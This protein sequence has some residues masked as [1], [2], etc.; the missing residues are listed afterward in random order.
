MIDAGQTGRCRVAILSDT[1]GV[2]DHRVSEIVAQCDIA[3]HGGDI[4]GLAVLAGLAPLSGR[5]YA[6]FGNNDRSRNWPAQELPALHRLPEIVE[7]ALPGGCLAVIHGHQAPAKGRHARLRRR[8]PEARAVVYGHSHHL[9]IDRGA[10]PWVLN[11]GA[12]GRTRTYGGAS[13][14]VLM[15]S[16]RD[17]ALAVHRFAPSTRPRRRVAAVGDK[18]ALST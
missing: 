13:C 5:V 8:F 11:P 12:A 14:L 7:L 2:L 1:H 10:T 4:G 17:W 6:V 16:D 9:E 18:S 15:A 3:V